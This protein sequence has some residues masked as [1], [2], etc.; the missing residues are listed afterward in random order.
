MNT[1]MPNNFVLGSD[2]LFG[3]KAPWKLD[4]S[5]LG[6][7]RTDHH[8]ATFTQ[9]DDN[10]VKE[11]ERI[12]RGIRSILKNNT[13]DH[14]VFIGY[15]KECMFAPSLYLQYGIE[16]DTVFLVNNPHPQQVFEPLMAFSMV[17]NIYT[18]PNLS[19]RVISWAECNQYI[20]TIQPAHMSTRVSLEIS[21]LLMYDRY[22]VDYFSDNKSILTEI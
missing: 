12:H 16:F 5:L 7:L 6:Q 9:L 14:K 2:K 17:Y 8:I 15:E 18:K 1:T 22:H 4:D 10:F 3:T 19:N 11:G 13:F 20:R 21:G